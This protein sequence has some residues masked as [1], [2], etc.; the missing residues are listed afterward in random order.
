MY[1]RTFDN[2]EEL[3]K[4]AVQL[5]RQIN[6]NSIVKILQS[7]LQRCNKCI[8]TFQRFFLILCLGIFISQFNNN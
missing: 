1:E 4:A 8:Q 5:V 7:T 6:D 3:S 2:I